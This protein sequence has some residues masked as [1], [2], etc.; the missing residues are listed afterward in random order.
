MG[1]WGSGRREYARTPT[2]EE[3]RHLDADGITDLV[4]QPGEGAM[5]YWGGQEDPTASIRVVALSCEHVAEL[6]A[7][8]TL[9]LRRSGDD[10]DDADHDPEDIPQV[11]VDAAAVET[12]PPGPTPRTA[13]TGR[14]CWCWRI[15]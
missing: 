15:G 8:E 12:P 7:G 14:W 3:C 6:K 2:V 5:I 11:D 10:G 1:G 9:L 13:R 4:E